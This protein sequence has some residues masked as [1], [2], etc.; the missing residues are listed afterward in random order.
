MT[1]RVD[2]EVVEL[3]AGPFTAVVDQMGEIA[4]SAPGN[5]AIFLRKRALRKRTGLV[6]DNDLGGG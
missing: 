1:S 6:W 2:E 3:G 5:I 4:D